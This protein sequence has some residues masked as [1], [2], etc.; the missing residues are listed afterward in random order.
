MPTQK[1]L[2]IGWFTF[3]CCEDNTVIFTELLNDHWQEWLPLIEFRHAKVL[4]SK[5]ILKDL[6]VAFVEGAIA[7][8]EKE[9]ELKEIRK[10]S[11][12][13]VAVGSC[14]CTGMP[15]ALA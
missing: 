5:N 6:D 3:S 14:A 9:K 10:N 12:I 15:S 1:K 7:S 4:K 8:V 13:L 2:I 11:K